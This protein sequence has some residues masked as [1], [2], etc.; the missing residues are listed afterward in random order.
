MRVQA[1]KKTMWEAGGGLNTVRSAATCVTSFPLLRFSQRGFG[2]RANKTISEYGNPGPSLPPRHPP[3]LLCIC[4]WPRGE[5]EAAKFIF[6]P[7]VPLRWRWGPCH[8]NAD[9]LGEGPST[10][11]GGTLL[12]PPHSIFAARSTVSHRG[13]PARPRPLP[14]TQKCTLRSQQ[15]IATATDHNAI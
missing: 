13:E 10:D 11:V 14:V 3:C 2:L 7:V 6:S 1:V 15:N 8:T 5:R 9:V 4:S 12:L